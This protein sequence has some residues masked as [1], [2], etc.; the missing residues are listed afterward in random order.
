MND[1]PSD[2]FGEMLRYNF[3]GA[4]EGGILGALAGI[5]LIATIV[6]LGGGLE[7]VLTFDYFKVWVGVFELVSIIIGAAA[8]AVVGTHKS[9][10][11]DI[12]ANH[13]ELA[14]YRTLRDDGPGGSD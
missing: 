13:A 10:A 8:G 9:I 6:A 2:F 3:S 12:Q 11:G 4:K 5:V 7:H 1:H 14:Q